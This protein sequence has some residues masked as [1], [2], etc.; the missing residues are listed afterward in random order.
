MAAAATKSVFLSSKT[1]KVSTLVLLMRDSGRSVLLG[2]KKR[3]FGA[4]KWNGFGGKVEPGESVRDGA[5]REMLEECSVDVSET[6]TEA[7]VLAFDFPDGSC[8]PILVHVFRATSYTGV[9]SES[10]EMAPKWFDVSEIP[11]ADMW[12]DDQYWFPLFLKGERFTAKFE[13]ENLHTMVKKEI[14]PAAPP[15][16]P[17]ETVLAEFLPGLK[18]GGTDPP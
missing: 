4:G 17:W 10:E 7:G 16:K 14:S 3:G 2:M 15:D 11:F 13:F 12:E 18:P 6:L 1:R 8:G 9:V 5:V